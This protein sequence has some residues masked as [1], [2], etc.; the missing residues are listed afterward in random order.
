MSCGTHSSR[1]SLCRD[2]V[3]RTTKIQIQ[4]CC[5][6]RIFYVFV[7]K[8]KNEKR[9][10]MADADAFRVSDELLDSLDLDVFNNPFGG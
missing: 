9:G 4:T 1:E 5:D 3:Q 10:K 7:L 6:I 8:S 2:N